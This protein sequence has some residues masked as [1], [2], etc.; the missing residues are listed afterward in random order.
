MFASLWA[1]FCWHVLSPTEISFQDNHVWNPS[2]WFLFT[3]LT[4]HFSALYTNTVIASQSYIH[5]STESCRLFRLPILSSLLNA[6]FP[7]FIHVLISSSQLPGGQS[8]IIIILIYLHVL[9]DNLGKL[10][11]EWQ[12]I[13]HFNAARV[14]E[15]AVVQMGTVRRAKLHS[16]HHHPKTD[17]QLL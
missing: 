13:L 1:L 16:D 11:P 17:S 15:M 10:L 2:K 5:V 7:L 3:S 14:M 9:Q 8:V 6:E 12:T 4:G